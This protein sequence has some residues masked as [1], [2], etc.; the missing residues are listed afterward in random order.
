METLDACYLICPLP[1]L[2]ARK[3]LLSLSPGAVLAVYATDRNTL[4]DFPLFCEEQGHT[5]LS[6]TEQD[7]VFTFLV[8]ASG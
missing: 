5:L 6:V 2:K 4:K 1:V 3:K 8:C 7:G